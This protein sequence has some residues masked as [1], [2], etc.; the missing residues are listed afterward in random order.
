MAHIPESIQEHE[1][2]GGEGDTRQN[3]LA[4]ATR[5]FSQRGFANVSVREI[6]EVAGVA[7][8]TIYHYFGN[9]ERLFQEVIRQ[10]LSLQGFSALLRQ[11][12]EAETVHQQRLLIFIQQVL[13]NFPHEFLNPGLFLQDT[14]QISDVSVELALSEFIA[15]DELTRCILQEGILAGAFRAVD[16]G[17]A[18]AYLRNVLIAYKLIEAN[19]DQPYQAEQ[20]A[21][22]IFDLFMNGM[23][24]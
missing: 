19:T 7:P 12:V 17:P 23:R 24:A 1:A 4:A 6:C 10:N 13:K 20:T 3:I 14:T 5:L 21:Q 15:I 2:Q 22:T 16:V 11:A 8:P 9:K 18:A